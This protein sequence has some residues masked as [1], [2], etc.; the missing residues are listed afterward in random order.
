MIGDDGWP[1]TK[2]R[3][4]E[5]VPQRPRADKWRAVV[6]GLSPPKT[7]KNFLRNG[8]SGVESILM[9]VSGFVST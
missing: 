9:T 1:F 6:P 7:E 4:P 8:C 3:K 5:P 2:I